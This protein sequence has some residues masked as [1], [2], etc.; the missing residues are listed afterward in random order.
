MAEKIIFDPITMRKVGVIDIRT[1]LKGGGVYSALMNIELQT[2]KG[3]KRFMLRASNPGDIDKIAAVLGRCFFIV[4]KIYKG[5]NKIWVEI[6]AKKIVYISLGGYFCMPCYYCCVGNILDSGE[7]YWV[8][9]GTVDDVLYVVLNKPTQDQ[10]DLWRWGISK[11]KEPRGFV[12]SRQE[13]QEVL[14]NTLKYGRR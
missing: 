2:Y 6:F 10:L 12:L 4:D 11:G 13:T 9:G 3:C 5:T 8:S 7:E 1:A 14:R